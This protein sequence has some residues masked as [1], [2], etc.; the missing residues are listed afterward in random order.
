MKSYLGVVFAVLRNLTASWLSLWSL[1]WNARSHSN[2]SYSTCTFVFCAPNRFQFLFYGGFIRRQEKLAEWDKCKC[3]DE[4]FY[5]WHTSISIKVALGFGHWNTEYSEMLCLS[6]N[7]TRAGSKIFFRRGC[8][9]LLPNFNT[10]K[11]NSF[12]FAEYQLY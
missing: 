4:R 8:T 2:T 1:L 12:F 9:R 6:D 11:P 10:N 7:Q 3:N 5:R